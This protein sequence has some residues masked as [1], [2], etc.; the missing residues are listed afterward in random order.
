MDD[1]DFNPPR[2]IPGRTFSSAFTLSIVQAIIS[3]RAT[4]L[5]LMMPVLFSIR[6]KGNNPVDVYSKIIE[7][8]FQCHFRNP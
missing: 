6:C 4:F 8:I 1:Y 3:A 2:V 5:Y 7:I